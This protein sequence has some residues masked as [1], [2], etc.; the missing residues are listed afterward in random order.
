[1]D[2]K[3]IQKE[4]AFSSMKKEWNQL[5]EKSK[6]KSIYLTWEWLFTWWQ[7]YGENRELFIV[8]ILKDDELISILPLIKRNIKEL[9]VFKQVVIEFLG[10]GEDEK[11][12]VCSNLMEPIAH[13]DFESE[14]NSVLLSFL[15]DGKSHNWDQLIFRCVRRNS[16]FMREINSDLISDKFFIKEV[17]TKKN[18]ITNL[19]EGWD[20]FFSSLGQRTRKKI[21]RE[22]RFLE[23][24]KDFSYRF[25]EDESE[26]EGMLEAFIALSLKR[27][28]GGGACA[29]DK[30]I[31]FTK[32]VCFEY[33]K[34][35]MLK[36]SLMEVDGKVI[37]GNLD[38]CFKDTIY[39]YQTTYD[40]EF[41]PKIG[42]GMQG[43]LY[44]IENAA[45]EGFKRYDWYGIKKGSYKEHF[46]NESQDI[47]TVF[48]KKKNLTSLLV[49]NFERSRKIIK[50]PMCQGRIRLIRN[51]K[52]KGRS[53]VKECK[54]DIRK[55]LKN[56]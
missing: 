35:G 7:V 15:A 17:M 33:F 6:S 11:D 50:S 12:E 40:P 18:G 44:C 19:N 53:E 16:L 49:D 46:V 27:W 55:N 5:L 36:L 2:I 22:R 20:C 32:L 13:P 26:L 29:S 1:M 54:G 28:N 10:T 4:G 37:A 3:V 31:K 42:V 52:S 9:G 56:Q 24:Q 41:N 47:V 43:M 38:Y 51:K 25:L 30:F 8:C 14:I 21:R 23:S 34:K 39:G 45:E 48:V